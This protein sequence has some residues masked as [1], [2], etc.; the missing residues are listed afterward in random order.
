ME[1]V[2]LPSAIADLD[3]PVSTHNAPLTN[4]IPRYQ[5]IGQQVEGCESLWLN[6]HFLTQ[7]EADDYFR[8]LMSSHIWPTSDYEVFG[9]R[10]TLPRQQTWHADEGIVY[11]YHN[12]LLPTRPWS[13]I[14]AKLRKTV[15]VA[16]G[17]SFNAVLANRYRTGEDYVGWHSDDE[18]EMGLEP[19][20][21]SVSLGN[22]REFSFRPR[23]T[24][25][26][27]NTLGATSVELSHGSLLLMAADFQQD[28][29]HA[30]LQS[31]ISGERINLTFRY[32]YPP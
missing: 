14:L 18:A 9:R 28:W 11:S 32:V 10:F 8:E 7:P 24:Q 22:K 1:L 29:Q 2:S 15:E 31:S 3:L 4:P 23:R 17:H 6:S 13:P 26:S 21:A 5:Q 30:V 19:V 16:T 27:T 25:T 20:I 12:N